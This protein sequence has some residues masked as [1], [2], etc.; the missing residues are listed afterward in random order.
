MLELNRTQI[1]FLNQ[2]TARTTSPQEHLTVYVIIFWEVR[3][4]QKSVSGEKSAKKQNWLN[5]VVPGGGGCFIC[6]YWLRK[7]LAK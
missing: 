5:P 6:S 3:E 1:L 7:D 2:I 4:I